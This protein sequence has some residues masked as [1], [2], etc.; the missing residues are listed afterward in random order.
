MALAPLR[1]QRH[2]VAKVGT[3]KGG[4]NQWQTIPKNLPRMQCQEPYRFYKRTPV[5]AGL[6]SR[7]EY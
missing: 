4:E 7:A 3:S 1:M 6:A 2:V 5:P